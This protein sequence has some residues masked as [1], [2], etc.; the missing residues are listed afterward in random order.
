MNLAN[1]KNWTRAFT[2]DVFKGF[3]TFENPGD[4]C[5]KQEDELRRQSKIMRDSF[6][7]WVAGDWS[8]RL[9]EDLIKSLRSVLEAGAYDVVFDELLNHESRKLEF[10][11]LLHELLRAIET[12]QSF[13]KPLSELLTWFEGL[14]L[15]SSVMKQL[16]T[17]LMSYWQPEKFVA[18]VPMD[19]DDF[20]RCIQEDPLGNWGFFSVADYKRILGLMFQIK[21][22]IPELAPRDMIDMEVFYRKGRVT[23]SRKGRPIGSNDTKTCVPDGSGLERPDELNMIL[24]GP[25]GTGKTYELIKKYAPMFQQGDIKRWEFVTFH[26]SYGY[27]EFVEGLKP[28]IEAGQ[29]TYRVVDGLFKKMVKRAMADPDNKYA[30]FIDEINRANIAKVLGELITLIEKDKRLR[31]NQAKGMWEGLKLPLPYTHTV[32]PDAE[33]FGAPDNLYVIGAMNTADKSIA[34]LDTALRRRFEFHELMPRPNLLKKIAIDSYEIDL[35]K[36]LGAMNLRISVLYNRE[37]QIGHSYFWAVSDFSQ[38]S[39]VFMKKII[40]LLQEYFFDDW[41][42]IK[43]VLNDP[44]DDK[45]SP[46]LKRIVINRSVLPEY[47]GDV[48]A[49]ERVYE[50]QSVLKPEQIIRIYKG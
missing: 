41:E 45:R 1:L 25:P 30:L 11:K 8:E 44:E 20:L 35:C 15:F 29:V 47:Q 17:R 13:E 38:L 50:T 34:A 22:E 33:L 24:Y 18:I 27:E 19:L 9:S 16:P 4:V 21:G 32:E 7:S 12:N 36:L 14:E 10:M 5:L 46:I 2:D 40:P 39:A 3:K 43:L 23:V 26:Q 31:W 28:V 49:L 37:H 42:K 48:S 6:E